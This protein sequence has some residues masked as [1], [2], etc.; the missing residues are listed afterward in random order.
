M[1]FETKYITTDIK[2]ST[3][4]GKMRKSEIAFKHHMLV[5]FI[6]GEQF[7]EHIASLKITEA[8]SI[9]RHI[10]PDIDS[11]LANFEEPGKIDLVSFMEKNYMF[12][13]PLE[14]FSYL[15]GRALTTFKRDFFNAFAIT[16]QRWLT[17]KR[18]ERA[19][20][21]LSQKQ[22]KSADIYLEVGFE[23]ISHFSFAFKKKFG[24]PPT[25]LGKSQHTRWLPG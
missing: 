21:L 19:H 24:Y 11:V 16:P 25:E 15:T 5:W 10:D 2:L 9:L 1:N 4:E 13:M 3:Y 23:N 6:A 8:I 14:K 7:P 20:Y 17:N 18:L 12:S 22:A